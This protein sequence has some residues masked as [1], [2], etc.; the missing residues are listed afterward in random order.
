[1]PHL[2][3]PTDATVV[4]LSTASEAVVAPRSFVLLLRGRESFRL[5]WHEWERL[6]AFLAAVKTE[7]AA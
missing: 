4:P 2:R 5:S 6:A 3:L 7:A 1:M